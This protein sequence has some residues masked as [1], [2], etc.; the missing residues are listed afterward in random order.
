MTTPD[1]IIIGGGPAGYT[2]ALEAAKQGAQ[3]RLYEKNK[4]GGTCLNYGCI[5]TKTLLESTALYQKIKKA[6]YFGITVK[7]PEINFARIMQRKNI[8]VSKLAK[9]LEKELKGSTTTPPQILR[10]AAQNDVTVGNAHES[11]LSTNDLKTYRL[12]DLKTNK[13][14]TNH[15]PLTTTTHGNIEI[16]YEEITLKEA[17]TQASKVIIATG[18]SPKVL[19]GTISTDDLLDIKEIPE[20]LHI[21]GAGAVGLEMATIFRQLGSKVSISEMADQILPGAAAK[22]IAEQLQKML[23]KQGLRIELSTTDIPKADVVV[24]CI[25]RTYNTA[26]F[27]DAGLKLGPQG[28]VI[29][30]DNLHTNLPGVFAAGDINGKML[31]AHVAYAQGKAAALNSLGGAET[32]DYTAVP[33]CVFTNPVL[34]SVGDTGANSPEANTKTIPFSQLGTAQ[35]KGDTEG[36]LRLVLAEDSKQILGIQILGPGAAELISTATLL[37]QNKATLNTLQDT[38]W[39]HPT[40]GEIFGAQETKS[41]LPGLSKA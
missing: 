27:E 37:V 35:A 38:I 17:I 8:V 16:I 41:T 10:S 32:V 29:V 5:P 31:L 22:P 39:T 23:E 33:Y 34:A 18:T 11:S 15:Q 2:A 28:E 3:V 19:D 25:G 14:T 24:S 40:L 36:F 7:D 30:D 1:L 6:S 13:P 9:G 21:I 12:N 4:L 26:C 20:K